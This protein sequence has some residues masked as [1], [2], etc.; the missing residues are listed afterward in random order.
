MPKITIITQTNVDHGKE[1]RGA[2]LQLKGR[3]Q[4]SKSFAH[5]NQTDACE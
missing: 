3:K 5:G 1:K 4:L 2:N